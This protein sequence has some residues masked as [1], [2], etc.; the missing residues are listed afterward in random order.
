MDNLLK[1]SD[2]LADELKETQLREL[3]GIAVTFNI[4][5]YRG[6]VVRIMKNY[7]GLEDFDEWL[8]NLIKNEGDSCLYHMADAGFNDIVK[9]YCEQ[10]YPDNEDFRNKKMM[11]LQNFNAE[12]INEA[13]G[14]IKIH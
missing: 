14:L 11:N 9:E 4:P 3:A 1:Y 10:A 7:N 13:E 6:G 12:L 2:I 8:G 5:R